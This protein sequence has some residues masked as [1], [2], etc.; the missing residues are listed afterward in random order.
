MRKTPRILVTGVGGGSIGHQILHALQLLGDRYSIVVTDADPFSFGLYLVAERHVVPFASAPNYAET[1]LDLLRRER[2]DMLLPGT[3]AEIRVL[4]PLREQIAAAGCLLMAS[5]AESIALCND[6]ARLYEWLAAN[7]SDVPKS[8]RVEGWKELVA[9]VGFPIVGKPANASS[10]SR[11]VAILANETEV[12]RYIALFPGAASQI[13]F[14]EYVGD[15]NSEYTVGVVVS[16]SG[17]IID[18]F[19]LH[20]VLS[21]MSL[22]ASRVIG[23]KRYT[24]STGYSQGVI[25]DD[26]KIRAFCEDLALRLELT[27]PVNIQLRTHGDDIK[28][29]EVHP[30][31]S[32]TTSIRAD[33]GFN[34]PDLVIRDQLLGETVGRQNYRTDV[35][36]IRAFRAILV[37]LKDM[38]RRSAAPG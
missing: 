27:G 34:E 11:D 23:G 30:R 6:K 20:R 4:T 26:P 32:G 35:A 17:R 25:V 16:R 29:F 13:V 21:G 12:E 18:S 31:F 38:A 37:P 19:V 7:G 33:A 10:G 22:G 14:Q 28:V 5:S 3:E 2:I 24:L 15:A 9:Q 36:A 1:I 8:A